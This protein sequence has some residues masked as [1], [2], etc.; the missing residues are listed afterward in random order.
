[1]TDIEERV[2]ELGQE[3]YCCSQIIM[4][5]GL[6]M[7]EKENPDLLKAVK[8]LCNGLCTQKLCGTLAAGGCL[9]SLYD[10]HYAKVLIPEL[11][12]WFKERFGSLDCVDLI[13]LGGRN[14]Q[15]CLEITSETCSYCLELLDKNGLLENE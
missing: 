2:A 6:E 9:L 3:G 8:G 11:T 14:Y 12:Y 13:G 10:E 7:L 5:I 1:M 15:R 4:C